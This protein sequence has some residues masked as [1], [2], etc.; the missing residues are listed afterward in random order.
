MPTLR[1][2]ATC[3]GLWQCLRLLHICKKTG[4]LTAKRENAQPKFA[5]R[6]T[7]QPTAN[8]SESCFRSMGQAYGWPS[9][10]WIFDN[11]SLQPSPKRDHLQTAHICNGFTARLH[12][13]LFETWVRSDRARSGADGY[14][15]SAMQI[16]TSWWAIAD[17]NFETTQRQ[18]NDITE[19]EERFSSQTTTVRDK[20]EQKMMRCR[21]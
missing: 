21:K 11:S 20:Y 19:S 15:L 13:Q 12:V 1:H 7:P 9:L 5:S 10:R 2:A 3:L 4:V 18:C 8:W 17:Y 14:E 6:Q 16:W